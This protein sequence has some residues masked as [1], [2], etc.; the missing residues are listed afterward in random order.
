MAD[1]WKQFIIAWIGVIILISS[2]ALF[3]YETFIKD[4][5]SINYTPINY[6]TENKIT[7]NYNIVLYDTTLKPMEIRTQTGK[8]YLFNPENYKRSK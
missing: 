8:I 7:N 5:P 2:I 6:S 1:S 4:S 3:T